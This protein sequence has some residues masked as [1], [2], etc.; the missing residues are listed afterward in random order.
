[1]AD[2]RHGG[3]VVE[4]VV[5]IV[6]GDEPTR[7]WIERTVASAGLHA[8]GLST[9]SGLAARLA[10]GAVACA[11]LDVRLQDASCF[12]L[13]DELAREGA[14][15]LFLTR[16]RC[17]SSCVRALK[18]GAVDFL[19]VPCG[20]D[21]LLN[22]VRYALQEARSSLDRRVQIRELCSR[23]EL[24]SARE[25][26][27]FELVTDGLLNKQIAQRL[28]IAEITVQIHRSRVMRKMSAASFAS[29][30][31]MADRLAAV[32]RS[33][34]S[35]AFFTNSDFNCIAPMPSILQS[36]S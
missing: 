11:I 15:I 12:E 4:P 27:V 13:Q 34:G 8:I 35:Y 36:M 7:A 3:T 29:L 16:E 32:K 33:K 26:E 30:V 9:A 2:Q 1:M 17:I 14:A 25:R 6:N 22:A 24:L 19:T 28:A 20:A 21:R 5:F 23:Y 10:P 18:A 31:R